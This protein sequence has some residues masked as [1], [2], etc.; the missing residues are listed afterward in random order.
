MLNPEENIGQLT[1]FLD[2]VVGIERGNSDVQALT[3]DDYK[4]FKAAGIMAPNLL[5]TPELQSAV[6]SSLVAGRLN[7]NRR[8]FTDYLLDSLSEF[9]RP[10]QKKLTTKTRRAQFIGSLKG[11]TGSLVRAERAERDVI[12]GVSGNTAQSVAAG[13]YWVK[14]TVKMLSTMDV[15]VIDGRVGVDVTFAEAA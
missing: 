14:V 6:T 7:A 2:W 15:I 11:F 10:F 3:I 8:A 12:D 13:I 1:E 5:G 9:A 4:A